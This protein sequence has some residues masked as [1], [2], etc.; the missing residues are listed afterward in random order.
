MRTQADLK[1]KKFL[2]S[3]QIHKNLKLS[4]CPP[5]KAGVWQHLF[6]HSKG[7]HI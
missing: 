2:V 5:V 7:Y 4:E 3:S 1:K 6:V